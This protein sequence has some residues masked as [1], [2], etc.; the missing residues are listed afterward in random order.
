MPCCDKDFTQYGLH[1]DIQLKVTIA[2]CNLNVTHCL[3]PCM[4]YYIIIHLSSCCTRL[5]AHYTL[6]TTLNTYLLL[7]INCN[8]LGINILKDETAL[9][10]NY[11]IVLLYIFPF[12]FSWKW[13]MLMNLMTTMVSYCW[14]DIIKIN[15]TIVLESYLAVKQWS[16]CY[17]YSLL[18]ILC[19]NE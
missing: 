13:F 9:L 5:H 19:I 10:Y 14:T 18:E 11:L 17:E 2:S 4:V 12:Y 16:V 6:Y 7:S 1:Y 15:G 3:S 8:I